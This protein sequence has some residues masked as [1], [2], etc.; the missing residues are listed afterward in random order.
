[1][2]RPFLRLFGTI[3]L[4]LL[5]LPGVARAG[6]YDLDLTPLGEQT[7]GG[8]IRDDAAFRSLSSELGVVMAPQPM[9]P[10]DSLGLSGFALSADFTISTISFVL[11]CSPRSIS[12]VG[13]IGDR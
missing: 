9:D 7:A 3:G 13:L 8:I 11:I 12:F 1:M 5:V 6:K 4:G 2:L 10:A